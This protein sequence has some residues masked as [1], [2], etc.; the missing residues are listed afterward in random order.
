MS[1]AA[2]HKPPPSSSQVLARLLG[3]DSGGSAGRARVDRRI[4]LAVLGVIALTVV[5]LALSVWPLIRLRMQPPRTVAD[6]KPDAPL[7]AE[8]SEATSRDLAQVTGRSLFAVPG[9]PAP[10]SETARKSAV[11][12][13]YGGPAII[14]MVN[15]QVFFSDGKRLGPGDDVTGGL[16]V[17]AIDAPWS[18]RLEWEGAE[19]DV[20]FFQRSPLLATSD[21]APARRVTPN[22]RSLGD[23][24]TSPAKP[25]RS[26]SAPSSAPASTPTRETP[27]PP[28]PDP[29]PPPEPDPAGAGTP[30]PTPPP[31]PANPAPGT[32]PAPT[33]PAGDP[34]AEPAAPPPPEPEPEKQ[35][36]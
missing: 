22:P 29:P 10:R 16:K 35:K 14:A 2:P 5:L 27:A 18:A 11:P 7:L 13:K 8:F 23:V 24:L 30:P 6:A 4:G 32:N 3:E 20:E 19:F 26:T 34:P 31:A 9:P 12:T 17:L 25:A 28:M 21:D 36:S 1:P 33:P 15:D